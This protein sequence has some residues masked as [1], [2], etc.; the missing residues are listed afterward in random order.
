LSLGLWETIKDPSIDTAVGLLKAVLNA[1]VD[2]VVWNSLTLI[3]AL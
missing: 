1:V 2:D 3:N